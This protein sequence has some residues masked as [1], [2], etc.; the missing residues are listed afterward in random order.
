VRRLA[1]ICLCLLALPASAVA[2]PSEPLG[3]SGRWIT[4]AGGRVVILHGFNTVP[5][6]ENT[7]PRDIGMGADNARWLAQNGFNTIRLG[8]YY[9]RVEPQ[10]GQFDPSYLSD[11]LR[12]QKELAAEGIFTLLD[13]HQ[14]Q[15]SRKYGDGSP[16]GALPSRGFADWFAID[17]GLPNTQT[18]YSAGYLSN[19]A[20]ERAYDN[21]WNDAPAGDG[22]GL[23]EHFARG[24]Q[25]LARTFRDRS[26]LL[27]Y[28]LF[29]EPWPGSAAPSC[30]SPAGC[31]PGGFDQTL[32]TDFFKKVTTAVRQVDSRHLVFYEPNLEFDLGAPTGVGPVPGAGGFTFHAYC[33]QGLAYGNRPTDDQ[34]STEEE[35]TLDNA[36]AQTKRTGDALLLSETGWDPKAAARIASS[37]DRRMLSWQWWD[38]YGDHSEYSQPSWPNLIRAYPQLTAGTPRPWTWNGDAKTFEYSWSTTGPSGRQFRKGARSEIF[39][40]MDAYEVTVDGARVVSA[41]GARLLVLEQKRGAKTVSVRVQP[42]PPRAS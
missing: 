14:D 3:H 26:H 27:G 17:D 6:D 21:V 41:P 42:A 24:W 30:A 35:S 22:Q 15:L 13:V 20:L 38:Y 1:A 29:N 40:P 25:L 4:D 36:E 39:I 5:W 11:F 23:Q 16:I 28:D 9:A 7:L 18:A 33:A 19:P 37:A 10:P 31:P 8:L 34:C 32:L 2:Q 12:V